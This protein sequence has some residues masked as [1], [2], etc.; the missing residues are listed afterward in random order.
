[1]L[2]S[3]TSAFINGWRVHYP[4]QTFP[5]VWTLIATAIADGRIVVPHTV[6]EELSKQDDKVYAWAKQ[7][8]RTYV[9]MPSQQVQ[10][11]VGVI[12][13]HLP[14]PGVRDIADPFV[15]AEA[16]IRGFTVVTYEG[17]NTL[18]GRRTKHWDKRMPGIC[19]AHVV[20]CRI[21]P[22]ALEMLSASF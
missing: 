3:D 13:A 16:K 22:E 10:L 11:L 14:N 9:V 19:E 12:H 5:S 1:V 18:T 17:T 8:A 7:H 21:F 2:V 6:Y 4:P 20:P 15:I